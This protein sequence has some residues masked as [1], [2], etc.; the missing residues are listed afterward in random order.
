MSGNTIKVI[1][2]D[3]HALFRLGVKGGLSG[4]RFPDIQ[5]V[6]EAEYGASLFALLENT[7]ADIV[8]LD[9]LLPDISGIEVAR[10]LRIDHPA[11][12][13]LAISSE[14]STETVRAL[15]EIGI[16][17]FI[18]KRQG[19]PD[20]LADAIRS[21]MNGLEYFGSD[22]SA[23]IY[24]IYVSKKKTTDA[25]P[26]FTER[27]REIIHLC[28][29]GLLSKEIAGRLNISPRTVDCHKKNIFEK[30]DLHNTMEVVQY[31]LKHGIISLE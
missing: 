7:V 18:S 1:L 14:N 3:D 4:N 30:L 15:L 24:K 29:K 20:E 28:S 22:I 11:V 10:R 8:L 16:D 2:A 31:A 26:E 21:I 13:I 12:K 27:E 9:I 25:T 19:N 5:I 23:I 17:G 6:G